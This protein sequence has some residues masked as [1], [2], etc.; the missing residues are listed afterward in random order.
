M[1]EELIATNCIKIGNWK[2]KNGDI[3]KYYF[4]IKNII[5]T[6][7]LLVKIGDE[8][9]KKLGDFDIICGLPYGG[10]PIATYI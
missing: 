6:P 2:L 3:S 1:I 8:L 7:S 5:S 9:Y 10:L 4:D